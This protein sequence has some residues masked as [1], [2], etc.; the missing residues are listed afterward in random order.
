MIH[1]G[2]LWVKVESVLF[3]VLKKLFLFFHYELTEE[4]FGTFIEFIKFGIVGVSNTLVSYLIYV[5]SLLIIRKINT[6]L[7]I[8]LFVS[9]HIMK[10]SVQNVPSPVSTV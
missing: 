4:M 5:F 6:N 1:M 8:D 9:N 3:T 10:G 7:S 2:D